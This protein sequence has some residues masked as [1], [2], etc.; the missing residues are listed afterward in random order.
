MFAKGQWVQRYKR[1]KKLG[2][3]TYGVVY[4]AENTS[5]KEIVAIKKI[6]VDDNDEGVPSTAIR[7]ISLLK[8]LSHDNII[9]LKETIYFNDDLYLVFEYFD[10]DLK[11]YFNKNK[12]S[13]CANE[14]KHYL[15]QILLAID[16]C[17]TNRIYHRDL[18]PQNILINEATKQIQLAD[19]GLSRTITLPNRTWTHEVVTL[20]YRSPEILL[21]IKHYSH[22]TDIWSIGCIFGEFCNQSMALFRGDSEICQLMYIFKNL[23]TPSRKSVLSTLP[24]FGQRF[25]KWKPK[26]M[27]LM[28]PS[29]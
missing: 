6:Y 5:T 26:P 9:Q 11:K 17:H 24:F 21:G 7:E 16:Y 22:T 14:I 10:N 27:K 1:L 15:H 12:H 3:G 25:P 28:I 20:W 4:K 8:S 29:L 13:I 23:G 19:F 2:E 18:K